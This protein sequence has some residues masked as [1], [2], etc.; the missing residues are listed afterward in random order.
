LYF[1]HQ[2]KAVV[3]YHIMSILC[4]K[5][6]LV[7]LLL[8]STSQCIFSDNCS[9]VWTFFQDTECKKN[10]HFLPIH[11]YTNFLELISHIRKCKV[12]SRQVQITGSQ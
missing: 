6:H 4:C 12:Q 2:F 1:V 5:L 9:S 11:F 8:L 3:T 10:C 7:L